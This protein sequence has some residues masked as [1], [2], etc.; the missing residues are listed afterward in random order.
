MA[1]KPARYERIG[2]PLGAQSRRNIGEGRVLAGLRQRGELPFDTTLAD[3]QALGLDLTAR[4]RKGKRKKGL[5]PELT[6]KEYKEQLGKKIKDFSKEEKRIYNALAKREGRGYV[7]KRQSDTSIADELE[8]FLLED[9]EE[10]AGGGGVVATIED[11]PPPPPPPADIEE[12]LANLPEPD[13]LPEIGLEELPIAPPQEVKIPQ[14]ISSKVAVAN[15][16]VE[17]SSDE[18]SEFDDDDIEYY[19]QF[20]P[21]SQR[22]ILG[23][24]F[25]AIL[26]PTKRKPKE[27]PVFI[28]SKEV[29]EEE[30]EDIVETPPPPT[31]PQRPSRKNPLLLSNKELREYTSDPTLSVQE[32]GRRVSEVN[33]GY[34]RLDK[35]KIK[36][37]REAQKLRQIEQRR[38]QREELI[39]QRRIEE[40]RA[41]ERS[42]LEEMA[43]RDRIVEETM[44][45]VREENRRIDEE[46]AEAQ[47]R[48]PIPSRNRPQTPVEEEEEEE[49]DFLGDELDE[50]LPDPVEEAPP[51]PP[52]T[53]RTARRE[54][55]ANL[56]NPFKEGTDEARQ[57]DETKRA[58]GRGFVVSLG[59]P[60]SKP[61]LPDFYSKP[62][63][64]N[65]DTRLLFQDFNMRTPEPR[66]PP[67]RQRRATTTPIFAR[68]RLQEAGVGNLS[69]GGPTQRYRLLDFE[70]RPRQ[71]LPPSK[72]QPVFQQLLKNNKERRRQ[73]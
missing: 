37:E 57:Y 31:R 67:N 54:Y 27:E 28:S 12:L 69:L 13:E 61:T 29:D 73:N 3:A 20:S 65:P 48:R 40:E 58:T 59:S 21:R 14:G 25:E 26:N 42:R 4:P 34:V 43:R 6:K 52:L 39:E 62:T 56:E 19:K 55:I 72:T 44:R 45:A 64:P 16:A 50:L 35:E 17:T 2:G 22:A 1:E 9:E 53:P 41:R 15:P 36:R 60:S 70:A 38:I 51:P 63:T 47:R 24:D 33:L 68:E 71:F 23:E 18:E 32:R 10:L 66:E 46:I 8:D 30:E 5:L 7:P 11:A 49:E